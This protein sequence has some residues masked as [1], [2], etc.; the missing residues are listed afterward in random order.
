MLLK[1]IYNQTNM[2]F[3]DMLKIKAL[4]KSSFRKN[5]FFES[6]RLKII[7]PGVEDLKKIISM[8]SKSSFI[9]FSSIFP[10]KHHF[11]LWKGA[12]N[13]KKGLCNLTQTMKWKKLHS[14][15]WVELTKWAASFRWSFG[16]N[17]AQG[18]IETTTVGKTQP[19]LTLNWVTFNPSR[20][21]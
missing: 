10:Q 8:N 18:S 21:L 13:N 4:S 1:A 17:S 11:F 3:L 15:I 5:N 6:R 7:S 16:S 14:L 2:I 20:Y 12:E 9:L 19:T